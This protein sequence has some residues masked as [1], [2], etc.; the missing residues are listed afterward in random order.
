MR[1]Q[2]Q[3]QAEAAAQAR[4]DRRPRTK[5]RDHLPANSVVTTTAQ[6]KVDKSEIIVPATAVRA[7]DKVH[8]G[9]GAIKANR[10]RAD[11]KGERSAGCANGRSSRERRLRC[12]IACIA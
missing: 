6:N 9:E 12:R 1:G 7:R 2:Q 10:C 11:R 8:E 3:R 4:P 5:S